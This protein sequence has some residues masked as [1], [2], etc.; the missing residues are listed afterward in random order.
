MNICYCAFFPFLEHHTSAYECIVLFTKAYVADKTNRF[1]IYFF[2]LK[3]N[4]IF[5]HVSDVVLSQTQIVGSRFGW[6]RSSVL[7]DEPE[8]GRV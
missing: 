2:S 7:V 3:K 6:V 1:G 8:F 5:L 4:G